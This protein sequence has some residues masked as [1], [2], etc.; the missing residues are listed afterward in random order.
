MTGGEV[1]R[2]LKALATPARAKSSA[3]FFKTGPGQYGEGDRFMGVSVPQQRGVARRFGALPLAEA[4]RL[5]R[6]KIHEERL[7]ALFILVRQYQRGDPKAKAAV[8]KAYLANLEWVNNWDLVDSSAP[9]ILGDWL[10]DKDPAPLYKLARSKDL[11]RRRVAMLST[12]AFINA[13]RHQHTFALADLLL[14]DGHDLMHKA[15]GWMLREV[16]KRVDADLLRAY[17]TKNAAR[18][19]RTALRYS[20]EKFSPAERKRWLK[21]KV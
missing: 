13:G 6:S 19:P 9:Y 17:L 16:G 18:M 14:E 2:A 11:W 10:K 5:L 20:I 15:V 3:W 12:A 8:V 21:F 7:T 4:V 1:R